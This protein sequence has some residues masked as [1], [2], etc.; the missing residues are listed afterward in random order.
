MATT[1][2]ADQAS[3]PSTCDVNVVDDESLSRLTADPE[4]N[5]LNGGDES[6]TGSVTGEKIKKQRKKRASN[7]GLFNQ[8][9]SFSGT[10]ETMFVYRW[11]QSEDTDSQGEAPDTYILQEQV[12]EY[13]GVKSFKRKYPDMFRRLLDIKE[14]VYLQENNVVT[15][16]QCDLG[17]TALRLNDCLDIMAESYPEKFKELN[18]YLIV[19]ARKEQAASIAASAEANANANEMSE[20]VKTGRFGR[21]VSI[22]L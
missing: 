7:Y 2:T 12:S 1:T 15:E 5:T 6:Q 11:P 9:E 8:I 16:T 10:V 3:T 22:V 19:K 20:P 13:L 14:R 17:L 18:D 4:S 21:V